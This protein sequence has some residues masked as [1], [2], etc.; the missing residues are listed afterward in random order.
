MKKVPPEWMWLHVVAINSRIALL[1]PS[2]EV[3]M[4]L[5]IPSCAKA[6]GTSPKRGWVVVTD[7]RQ[8]KIGCIYIYNIGT[9]KL[10]VIRYNVIHMIQRFYEWYY[11][12]FQLRISS[13]SLQQLGGPDIAKPT[14]G[15]AKA[16][17]WFGTMGQCTSTACDRWNRRVS[18]NSRWPS[19]CAIVF[20]LFLI[21]VDGFSIFLHPLQLQEF[22]NA[23]N[24]CTV[25]LLFGLACSTVLWRQPSLCL[26][27]FP[28]IGALLSVRL[29][30]CVWAKQSCIGIVQLHA[31]S[32]Y[33]AFDRTTLLHTVQL[34]D[35]MQHILLHDAAIIQLLVALCRSR[36]QR[37]SK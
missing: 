6:S 33:I 32:I 29:K 26:L 34:R 15:E 20:W 17:C 21:F 8:Q 24:A 36:K 1:P 16:N 35:R 3:P 37:R 11:E 2:L 4:P 27:V 9:F 18:E 12:W 31:I 30:Y 13:N 14:P 10:E 5:R 7:L 22:R 23:Y 25:E 28:V 19:T